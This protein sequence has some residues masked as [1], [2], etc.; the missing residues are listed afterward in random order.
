M[1][2][3]RNPSSVLQSRIRECGGSSYGTDDRRY[4]PSLADDVQDFIRSHAIDDRVAEVLMNQSP[5]VQQTILD[6]GSLTDLRNPSSAL[7]ARIKVAQQQVG[8]GSG[9]TGTPSSF[10]NHDSSDSKG[11]HHKRDFGLK[12]KV[13][14]FIRENAIDD[15]GADHYRSCSEFVQQMVLDRGHMRNVRNTSSLL[16]S[17]ISDAE[18]EEAERNNNAPQNYHCAPRSYGNESRNWT[19]PGENRNWAEQSYVSLPS[20]LIYEIE[21]YIQT[22]GNDRDPRKAGEI[23]SHMEG[24]RPRWRPSRRKSAIS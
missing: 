23:A 13:E 16:E 17:R 15:K 14:E 8:A 7:M 24:P 18:K 6:K 12:A 3:A 4:Q 11:A 9:G 22:H 10:G 21:D 2:N 19:E 1:N 5:S 20:D